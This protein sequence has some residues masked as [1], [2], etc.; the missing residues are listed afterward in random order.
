MASTLSEE[1]GQILSEIYGHKNSGFQK[2]ISR[3]IYYSK[4][5]SS[6]RPDTSKHAESCLICSFGSDYHLIKKTGY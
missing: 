6:L 1:Y 3:G 5:C 2:K 4:I